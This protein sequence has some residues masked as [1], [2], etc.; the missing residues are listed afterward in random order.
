MDIHRRSAL[1]PVGS[2]RHVQATDL[3]NETTYVGQIRAVNGGVR[4]EPSDEDEATPHVQPD[5]PTGFAVTPSH[6]KVTLSWTNPQKASVTGYEYEQDGDGT[7]TDLTLTSADGAATLVADVAGLTNGTEYS[8]KIRAVTPIHNGKETEAVK[9]TP[10]FVPPKPTIVSFT[11]GDT[12]VDVTFGVKSYEHVTGWEYRIRKKSDESYPAWTFI[13]DSFLTPIGGNRQIQATDLENETTYVGQ[14]RAVNGGV[15]GEPSDEDEATPHVQPDAPSGFAVTPSHQKV[16]LSWTNPQKASVTGYEYEQ[17]GDGTWRNLTLTSADGATTL[18]A[19]VAG[20][21]NGTEYSF[22]IRAVTPIHNGK[23]TE[24]VKATPN[25]VPPK[26]VFIETVPGDLSAKVTFWASSYVNITSWEGRFKVKGDVEFGP[27]TAIDN[28]RIS[29]VG[30]NKVI[31]ANLAA[32]NTT[33]VG[34]LRAVNGGVK[35]P[36]SDVTEFTPHAKPGALAGFT[37][38]PSH[39]M[40]TL[41]WTNPNNANVTGYQYERGDDGNWTDLTLTSAVDA[42]TLQADVAGLTNGT[43]YSFRIR[44]VT[45]GHDGTETEAVKATPNAVPP[46]PTIVSMVPGDGSL[47]ITFSASSYTNIT[48]WESR[49]KK[50]ADAGYGPWTAIDGDDISEEGGNRV[51]AVSGLDNDATYVGLLRAVN[52]EVTGPASDEAEATPHAKPG[53]PSRLTAVAGDSAVTLI[54]TDPNN[55]HITGYEYDLSPGDDGWTTIAGSGMA[56]TTV[57]LIGL[58]NS[59]SYTIRL[60]AVTAG[61]KGTESAGVSATPQKTPPKPTID[62]IVPG[63]GKVTLTVSASS[64]ENITSWQGRIKAKG[65]TTIPEWVN[66][67]ATGSG[68]SRTI[69]IGDLTN[70]TT[71]VVQVLAVNGTVSPSMNAAVAGPASDEAEATPNLVPPKPTIVSIVPGDASAKIT[72]SASSYANI[73][74]WE[75]RFKKKADADYGAWTAI[76]GDDISEEGGDRVITVSGPRQRHDLCRPA[77]RRQRRGDRAGFR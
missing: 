50:K 59:T 51:I 75:S 14:I 37:V 38:T 58:T 55:T 12:T 42:T 40:V 70:G 36:A 61:H 17:N 66:V 2:N 41:S 46:K 26:P 16:T 27:W 15:R 63:E 1:D 30:E 24:S 21:T 22:K 33:Y 10:D 29:D 31:I 76:D 23:A 65:S 77:S 60:R 39:Q 34:Q 57:T 8:F 20:L 72:F 4:G 74:S 3:E 44:A 13:D 43:E 19:D 6:Q 73:T 48:S 45:L 62:S 25:I 5:A 54:W 11:P 69:E 47:T 9:A 56:T 53:A 68:A 49:L 52:G 18:A 67:T 7:W 32:N 28:E 64:Y 71:Y 35:G